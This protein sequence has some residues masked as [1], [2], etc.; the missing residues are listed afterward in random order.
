MNDQGQHQHLQDTGW[1][2]S[3]VGGNAVEEDEIVSLAHNQANPQQMP[4]AQTRGGDRVYIVDFY[5][6]KGIASLAEVG[7]T[8]GLEIQVISCTPS[9]SVV[10]AWQNHYIGL[11]AKISNKI[12]V[13]RKFS[14]SQNRANFDDSTHLRDLPVGTKGYV[15]G[16]DRAFLGY[17]GKL[18]AMGLKPGTMFTVI[19]HAFFNHLV[20]IEVQGFTLGLGKPE[21]DALCVEPIEVE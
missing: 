14:P 2:F 13:I 11:G 7:L 21:A 20:E 16:Y 19:R 3:F 10:I 9:G 8:H 17:R 1:H 6:K 5:S 12:G 15:V 18:L 4:L